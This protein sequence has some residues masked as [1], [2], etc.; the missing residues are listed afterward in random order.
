MLESNDG[1][2]RSGVEEA[3]TAATS[4]RKSVMS[5]WLEAVSWRVNPS[6]SNE[7]DASPLIRLHPDTSYASWS[8]RQAYH[9]LRPPAR[10]SPEASAAAA[11]QRPLVLVRYY[12]WSTSR[13]HAGARCR[14]PERTPSPCRAQQQHPS[15]LRTTPP[16]L[17]SAAEVG[18][19]EAPGGLARRAPGRPVDR[20]RYG[21][22]SIFVNCVAKTLRGLM[23]IVECD[24]MGTAFYRATLC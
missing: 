18:R 21:Q 24:S 9:R 7:H 1:D 4:H 16:L 8:R 13:L 17:I 20:H 12:W 23:S 5:A 19:A 15:S 22:E 3:A 10:R 2:G 14:V 6:G 11:V